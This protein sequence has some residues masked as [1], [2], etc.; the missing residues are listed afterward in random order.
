[1][2]KYYHT[3]NQ[4]LDGINGLEDLMSCNDMFCRIDTHRKQISEYCI[5]FVHICRFFFSIVFPLQKA[6]SSLG[7]IDTASLFWHSLWI[8]AGKPAYGVLAQIMR[9]T[10]AKDHYFV[11]WSAANQE[12]LCRSRMA[13]NIVVGDGREFWREC[14][15]M[16]GSVLPKCF[17][18][19]GTSGNASIAAL[20]AKKYEDIC[21]I[22]RDNQKDISNL[23]DAIDH[24]IAVENSCDLSVVAI[25]EVTDGIKSLKHDKCDG[26]EG[27]YSNHLL[28]SSEIF[29]EHVAS[30]FTVM[31]QNICWKLSFNLFQ[32]MPKSLFNVVKI[33]GA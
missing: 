8:N 18:M 15:R 19:D 16:S 13:D 11:R 27:M 9:Q 20:F 10:R 29:R 22:S 14:K 2:V 23:Q 6:E 31:L 7:R 30:L 26:N 32:K 12:Y 28:L 17:R 33:I 1:M 25:S 21:N 5:K 4:S 24:H 3:M